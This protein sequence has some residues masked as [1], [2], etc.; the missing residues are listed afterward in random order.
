MLEHVADDEGQVVLSYNL[1]AIAK[2]GDTLGNTLCLLGSEFKS[3]FL[4]VAGDVCP[5]AVI[6]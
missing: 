4:Q 5:T 6:A 1:L 3:Q 2:F